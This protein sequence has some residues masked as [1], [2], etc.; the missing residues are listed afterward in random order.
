[1]LHEPSPS[2]A[3][4]AGQPRPHA[5]RRVSGSGGTSK[6]VQIR[7]YSTPC[8]DGVRATMELWVNGVKKQ[9]WSNVAASWTTYQKSVTLSGND[10]IEV[11]FPNDCNVGG[12][13]RNLYVDYVV[14]DGRTVQA[15][16]GE[17]IIDK[18]AGDAAFD[19]LNVIVGQ[20]GLY[21]NGALRFVV[22]PQASAACYDANGNM[23]WRLKDGVAYEQVWDY[24]NRLASVTDHATGQ[25]TT[26]T[27]DGHGALVKKVAGGQTAIY[28]GAHYEKNITTGVAT[29]YYYAGGRRVAMRQGGVVYYLL[30]DHLSSTV[31]V[32]N[33][34]GSWVGELRYKPYGETRYSAG[35]TPS[36]YRW[37][38]QR[39]EESLGLYQMGARWY[40]PALARWLS[41]DT[42][43]PG[44]G[45]PQ[46]LNR[47]AYVTNNPL[48][49]IDPS[50]HMPCGMACP[51][52]Y[53]TW[54]INFGV[55]YRGSWDPGQQAG[56][57][58]RAA[59]AASLM[60]DLGPGVGDVKGLI[61][62]GTGRD[63]VS[64][65][66]LG[67]WRWVGL[68]GFVGLA[69][70][71]DLR[72]ADEAGDAFRLLL[73]VED[74]VGA[75]G[76]WH[77][78]LP[79]K[80]MRALGEHPAFRGVFERD[81]FLVRAFDE[82]GH[83]G[84]QTWHRAY[85]DE[86]ARWLKDPAHIDATQKDFLQF[87]LEIYSRPDMLERFPGAVDLLNQALEALE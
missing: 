46:A 37:T 84:Y 49:A 30:G 26:F 4:G 60:L 82:A 72:H 2:L 12:Q 42:L 13:D 81:D 40:D 34:G 38:G 33:S 8:N 54:E 48:N 56:N 77:H 51:Y 50:G 28:I 18:G 3:S 1:M 47:Y 58:S 29:G 63:L 79:N 9:T 68:L 35:S 76:Q 75:T 5:V 19:G 39:Q 85:D 43:V 74:A 23:T 45:N 87:L 65:E 10:Q 83:R 44:A 70:A 61:E 57:R 22:G 71:R 62:V 80:V 24:E 21:W 15:E 41:A 59:Q 25:T 17:A 66:A 20:Q 53:T 64:G 78:M 86:I 32:L 67:A 69:E 14:V 31:K 27:Y 55:A 73:K 16:G 52:D 11:V 7:A 6:T 36:D